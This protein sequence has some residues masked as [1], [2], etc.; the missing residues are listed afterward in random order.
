MRKKKEK[1]KEKTNKT[2][3]TLKRDHSKLIFFIRIHLEMTFC[4]RYGLH[5][6]F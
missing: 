1:R 6:F 4:V 3:G 5:H 2:T